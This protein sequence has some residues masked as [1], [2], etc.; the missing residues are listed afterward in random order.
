MSTSPERPR[1]LLIGAG[2][3]GAPAA[4]ALAA[5]GA[6]A[7][8]VLDDDRVETSNLHRQVLFD[9]ADVGA[10]KIEALAR[11]LRARFPGCDVTPIDGRATPGTI[12]GHLA[13]ADVVVDGTDRFAVRFLAADAAWLVGKPVVHAACVQWRG[14][15]FVADRRGRPCY[16]C[17]F[18]DLPEGPAPDCVTAGVVGPV[19]GV[20]GGLAADAALSIVRGEALGLGTIATF[21]GL[22]GALRRIRVSPRPDC[23]LC[24]E[25]A[26][27]TSLDASRYSGP[28]CQA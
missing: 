18:E 4:W 3:V 24:G 17:L 23:A 16:R 7:I 26:R 8:D 21:D 20:I 19:C 15:V 25:P 11:S 1:V 14:T 5:S 9:D 2:G 6:V 28:A 22:T 13:R 12:L 27:I 10:P